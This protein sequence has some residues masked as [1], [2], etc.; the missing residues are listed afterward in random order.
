MNAFK[1]NPPV[2]S[3]S[4]YHRLVVTGPMYGKTLNLRAFALSS[5]DNDPN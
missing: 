3:K 2:M 5:A 4:R 1:F